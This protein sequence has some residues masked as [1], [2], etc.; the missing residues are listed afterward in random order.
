MTNKTKI[1]KRAGIV[2]SKGDGTADC[3]STGFRDML[4]RAACPAEARVST[5][6]LTTVMTETVRALAARLDPRPI[7]VR[8]AMAGDGNMT[9]LPTS[10][11]SRKAL[12]TA[13]R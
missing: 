7:E 4:L 1:A 11:I 13:G 5:A 3:M 10:G 12:A 8:L 2:L 9:G 6:A